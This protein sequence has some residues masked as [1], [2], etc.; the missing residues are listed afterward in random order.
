[1]DMSDMN[2]S[3]IG[4]VISMLQSNP[5][6]LK[7][8]SSIMSSANQKPEPPKSAPSADALSSIMSMLG[9]QK[10]ADDVTR[11]APKQPNPLSVFG[12]GEEIKNR[13]ALLSAVRPYLSETRKERL[14]TVIKLL[15]VAELG[16]LGSL[17]N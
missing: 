2:F 4:T 11:K 10:N 14:E 5:E 8:L 6:M 9:G 16:G 12:S 7:M 3:D 15:R 13:I 17:L 1:M